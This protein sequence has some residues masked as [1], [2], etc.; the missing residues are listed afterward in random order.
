MKDQVVIAPQVHRAVA[1]DVLHV[2]R[3]FLTVNERMSQAI[4]AQLFFRGQLIGVRRINCGKQGIAKFVRRAVDLDGSPVM[5]DPVQKATMLKLPFG[6]AID[7]LSFQLELHDR[8]RL[9]HARD[10]RIRSHA[11]G[12]RDEMFCRIIGIVGSGQMLERCQRNAVSFV[13]LSQSAI[14]QRHSQDVADQGVVSQAGAQPGHI[15]VAPDERHL[16]LVAQIVDDS[17]TS[18]PAIPAVAADDQFVDGQ[19]PD[20]ASC[21]MD[22]MQSAISNQ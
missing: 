7:H 15:V 5:I 16:R 22:Q 14:P 12:F 6:I 17:V 18:R 20:D 19:V 8:N 21:N 1:D 13:E 2:L 11:A 3:Q 9:L 10:D 4:H